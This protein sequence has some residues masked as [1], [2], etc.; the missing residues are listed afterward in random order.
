MLTKKV[1][2]KL[3]FQPMISVILP[4]FK[5]G[6]FIGQTLYSISSQTYPHWEVVVVD[7]AG[8]E[9]GTRGAVQA[10][11]EKHPDSRVEY[12]RHERNL[13]VSQARKTGWKASRG[14][15]IAFLDSDDLFL[16]GKLSEHTDLLTQHPSAVLVHGPVL[17]GP[18]YPSPDTRSAD[19][20]LMGDRTREYRIED[21][22]DYLRINRIC[23]SSV[24]CRREAITEDCFPGRMRYQAEDWFLW[25]R[26]AQKG[27]FLYHPKPL[28]FYREHPQS[29][30]SGLQPERGDHDFV[31]M[32]VLTLFFPH[33]KDARRKFLCAKEM[34][35]CIGRL[36]HL[37]RSNGSGSIQRDGIS[38]RFWLALAAFLT[39]LRGL[40]KKVLPSARN[41]HAS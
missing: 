29:Y 12:I 25:L 18:D 35:A 38:L 1:N 23:N 34:V 16:P 4:S 8:P 40:S 6:N 15:L 31:Q 5:M 36:A 37:A 24:V 19:W 11:S 17:R 27:T 22:A 10:F 41:S 39:W 14:E 7:D 32:E 20:S 2:S 9:D 33:A 30:F 3:I 26:L 13:G 21:S 28:T